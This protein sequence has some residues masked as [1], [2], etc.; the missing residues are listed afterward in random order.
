MHRHLTLIEA[1]QCAEPH[2]CG[3]YVF[4]IENYQERVLNE[5]EDGVVNRFR[6]RR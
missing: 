3:W 6:F 5:Q 1:A 2:G 4:A